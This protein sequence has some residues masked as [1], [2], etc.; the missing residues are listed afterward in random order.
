MVLASRVET[1]RPRLAATVK[2]PCLA[3]WTPGSAC[4]SIAPSERR[5]QVTYRQRRPPKPAVTKSQSI[6]ALGSPRLLRSAKSVS[7]FHSTSVQVLRL[8]C[9]TGL[10]DLDSEGDGG[11]SGDEGSCGTAQDTLEPVGD[12]DADEG[13]GPDGGYELGYC[14]LGTS[15]EYY[16]EHECSL[17]AYHVGWMCVIVELRTGPPGHVPRVCGTLSR[18]ALRSNTWNTDLLRA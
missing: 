13:P 1:L 8:L 16:L 10:S 17:D 5:K 12:M 18:I 9:L 14:T 11:P 4:V 15:L 6:S 7:F 3:A 2:I